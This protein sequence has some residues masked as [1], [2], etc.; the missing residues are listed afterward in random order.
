MY[1]LHKRRS[2]MLNVILIGIL[3]LMGCGTSTSNTVKNKPILLNESKALTKSDMKVG[4]LYIGQTLASVQQ[5]FGEPIHKTIVHGI[6]DP[7]WEYPNQ[8]F[9]VGGDPIWKID[10]SR[11]Y[12][13]NT[14]RGIHI[15]NTEK[16]VRQAYP[17][18]RWVQQDSQ[19]FEESK[20]KHYYID[21][22]IVQGK[23]SEISLAKE[24]P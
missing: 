10:V 6:G 5:N 19:L 22:S 14:T 24:N 23:V 18:I 16:D 9:T 12:S 20:D 11:K 8:G 21:F 13:G 15:G 3:F 4:K 7:Q 2:I 1:F 17:N